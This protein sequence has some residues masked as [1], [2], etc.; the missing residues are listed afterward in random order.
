MD[1]NIS[2]RIRKETEYKCLDCGSEMKYTGGLLW[3]EALTKC[4][5]RFKCPNCGSAFD[6]RLTRD[7]EEE[8]KKRAQERNAQEAKGKKKE[9]FSPF[10]LLTP[11]TTT[12]VML[13]G[14]IFFSG[15][16]LLS[17]YTQGRGEAW[18]L[19]TIVCAFG[20]VFMLIKNGER[21]ENKK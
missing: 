9:I 7:E 18:I 12:L 4:F 19:P 8:S 11:K 13:A 15:L 20:L 5:Y 17:E 16:C 21:G 14:V 2:E 6:H 10:L 3:N 1:E